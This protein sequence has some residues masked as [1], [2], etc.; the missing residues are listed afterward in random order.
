MKDLILLILSSVAMT[1]SIQDLISH[2]RK[3]GLA[4]LLLNPYITITLLVWCQAF[5][6][7]CIAD[8]T[9]K[10][11]AEHQSTQ[12]LMMFG[13]MYAMVFIKIQMDKRKLSQIKCNGKEVT[14][15]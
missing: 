9:F 15:V 1:Y 13:V 7:M 8:N 12:F 14:N 3:N 10:V 5:L 6:L 2:A 11:V 4:S